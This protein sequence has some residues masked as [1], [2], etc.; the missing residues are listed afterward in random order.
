MNCFT[1]VQQQFLNST[2]QIPTLAY[3]KKSQ[4][5]Q[6]FLISTTESLIKLIIADAAVQYGQYIEK[7]IKSVWMATKV[8]LPSHYKENMKNLSDDISEVRKKRDALAKDLSATIE[9]IEKLYQS[10]PELQG[11]K[12][13]ASVGS[14]GK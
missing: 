12:R 11:W 14:K 7:T 2:S 3:L 4:H 8:K 6:N 13:S 1:S 9:S 5:S 10:A